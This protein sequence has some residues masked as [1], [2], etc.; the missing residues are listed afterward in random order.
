[1]LLA[2]YGLHPVSGAFGDKA[3]EMRLPVIY[4]ALQPEAPRQ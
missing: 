1:M 3:V 2:G 4:E